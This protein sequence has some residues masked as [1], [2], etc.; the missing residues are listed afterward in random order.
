M[1]YKS[2]YDYGTEARTRLLEHLGAL[3]EGD[4]EMTT[5][6]GSLLDGLDWSTQAFERKKV[7]EDR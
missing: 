5:A 1:S 6:L 4:I 3:V 7:E 2:D